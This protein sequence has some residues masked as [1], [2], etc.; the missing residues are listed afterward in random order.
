MV[1][2]P[3]PSESLAGAEPPPLGA[4]AG[5]VPEEAGAAATDYLMYSGYVALAYW[6]ARSAAAADHSSR[7]DAFKRG[8]RESATFYFARILPRTRVHAAA[9]DSGAASLMTLAADEFGA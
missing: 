4:G 7:D 2:P 9:M 5:R 8:K 1:A 6:W 3:P